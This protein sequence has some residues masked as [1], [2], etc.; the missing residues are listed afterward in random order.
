MI[1]AIYLEAGSI[2]CICCPDI[3]GCRNPPA[4]EDD[5]ID[6]DLENIHLKELLT[7]AY[8]YGPATHKL[9]DCKIPEVLAIRKAI[10]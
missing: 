5:E 10:K 6:T 8:E 9:D 1:D 7:W 4:I 3:L 2:N